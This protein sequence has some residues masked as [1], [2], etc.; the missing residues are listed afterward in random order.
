MSLFGPSVEYALH[1][2][3][4][5]ELLGAEK[6]VSARDLAAIHELP[7]AFVRKLLTRLER[8][9]LIDGGEGRGGGWTLA[10]PLTEISYLAVVDAVAEDGR[11]FQCADIRSRFPGSTSGCRRSIAAE[12]CAIHRVMLDA[13]AA[14]RGHLAQRM[15]GETAAHV[16]TR[17]GTAWLFA[18]E[19][20]A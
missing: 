18:G 19:E 4:N 9:G 7:L 1:T 16:R 2:L 8:A 20:D 15:L 17:Y 12:P 10:R 13:E 6:R 14:M 5:L 11:L 3:L